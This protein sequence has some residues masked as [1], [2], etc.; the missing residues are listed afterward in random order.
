MSLAVEL[1]VPSGDGSAGA[2]AIA[3]LEHERVDTAPRLTAVGDVG[4]IRT[5]GVG[6]AFDVPR[7]RARDG[8]RS[9]A[10]PLHLHSRVP[11]IDVRQVTP[12]PAVLDS[13][14]DREI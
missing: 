13:A 6:R 8:V 5:T 3:E 9:D 7:C 14:R 2:V 11:V 12:E 1:D 4:C 10:R